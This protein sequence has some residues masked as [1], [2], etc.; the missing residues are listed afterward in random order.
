MAQVPFA[1]DG[2]G[3]VL[4]LHQF[5]EGDFVGMDA[6]LRFRTQGADDADAV[7]VTAGEERG[8]GGGTDRLGGVKAAETTSLASKAI[9]IWG[10]DVFGTERTDIGV[11][12]VVAKN[13]DDVGRFGRM[14]LSDQGGKQSKDGYEP[15]LARLLHSEQKK[16]GSRGAALWKGNERSGPTKR[17]KK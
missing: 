8:A 17:W 2:G 12:H 7:R 16:D 6:D 9:E 3:V 10:A 15:G 11:T 5:G 13:Q 4:L 1:E 14:T